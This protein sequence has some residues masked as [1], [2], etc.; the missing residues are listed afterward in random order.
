MPTKAT[1]KPSE[2][3]IKTITHDASES[4]GE[5]NLSPL[6]SPTLQPNSDRATENLNFL[7]PEMNHSEKQEKVTP[8]TFITYDDADSFIDNSAFMSFDMSEPQTQTISQSKSTGMNLESSFAASVVGNKRASTT[9]MPMPQH[10]SEEAN[11]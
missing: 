6:K 7:S 11:Q 5:D 9:P 3:A 10:Q 8:E 1:T 4:T 2:F